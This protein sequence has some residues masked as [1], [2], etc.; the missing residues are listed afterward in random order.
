MAC[1]RNEVGACGRLPAEEFAGGIAPGMAQGLKVVAMAACRRGEGC[2]TL[3]LSVARLLAETD[4]K[5]VLVDANPSQPKLAQR[6]G[7]MPEADWQEMMARR[8]PLAE[9]V[10]YSHH[11]RLALLPLAE[12][13][14]GGSELRQQGPDFARAVRTTSRTLRPR[15]LGPWADGKSLA[16]GLRAGT[17]DRC[18]DRLGPRGAK[19]SIDTRDRSAPA[20]LG[21]PNGRD[22]RGRRGR[23]L[24]LVP[25]QERLRGF[26]VGWALAN[27]GGINPTLRNSSWTGT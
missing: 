3:L 11:D 27:P 25:V 9:A 7:I 16:H 14:G 24:R 2:T 17:C 10:V 22:P 23:E 4:L 1:R 18:L 8:E 6:L 5:A 20:L 26:V 13:R 12:Q 15:A 21:P 19:R